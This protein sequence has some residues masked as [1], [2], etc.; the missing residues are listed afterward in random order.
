MIIFTFGHAINVKVPQGNMIEV[1]V[2]GAGRGEKDV[3]G[4]V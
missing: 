1:L 4:Q 2:G 3:T